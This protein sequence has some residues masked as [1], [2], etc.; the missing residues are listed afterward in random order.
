M[1]I[2]CVTCL[3]SSFDRWH[4]A[5]TLHFLNLLKAS[6]ATGVDAGGMEELVIVIF[7]SLAK[8][9]SGQ[10]PAKL[11]SHSL[12]NNPINPLVNRYSYSGTL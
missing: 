4:S 1:V 6:S 2:I 12:S 7:L 11:S 5:L 8:P 9:L 10:G 3:A